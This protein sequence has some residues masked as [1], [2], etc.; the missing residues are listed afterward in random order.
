MH[1][2]NSIKRYFSSAV[3]IVAAKRT[4]IGSFL[5]KLSSVKATELS[6]ITIRAALESKKIEARHVDEV[7]LGNVIS[8]GLG[9]HAARQAALGA[10]LLQ[11][12][13]ALN[14]NKVCA[15]GMKSVIL[16]AQSIAL[17]NSNCVVTGG[18]ESMSNIP[19]YVAGVSK[20]RINK[21]MTLSLY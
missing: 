17:G 16:G 5:G 12:T 13:I 6:S 1:S 7:I 15:S 3:Y 11:G 20:K 2:K 21:W 10:G 19:F 8:A 9:Q 4:P 18:F 14:I